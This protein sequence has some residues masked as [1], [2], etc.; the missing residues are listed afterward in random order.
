MS[1]KLSRIIK[2]L[3]PYIAIILTVYLLR[4]FVFQ[5]VVVRGH[6]MDPTLTDGE[7][8]IALKN[9]KIE[10]FD[11]ITFPAPDQPKKS[12]IKR[13]IG[14]PGETVEY[15]NDILYIDGKEH[16][17]PYLDEFKQAVTDGQPLTADVPPTK[18]PAGHY[19]VMGDNRRN[20]KDSR[21]IGSIDEKTISGD[22][23]FVLWPFDR[24]GVLSTDK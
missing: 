4:A 12:Y 5:P 13:V 11:I 6:S 7:W 8:S 17:E 23:K 9:T 24:F 15:K 1:L 20:S 3:L 21:Y 2:Y 22:V 10:R 18:V 16:K 14:L 19:F